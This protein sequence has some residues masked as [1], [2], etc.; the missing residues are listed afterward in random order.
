MEKNVLSVAELLRVGKATD[1]YIVENLIRPGEQLILAGPPKSGKSFLVSELALCLARPFN[2]ENENRFVWAGKGE[3][4]KNPFQVNRKEHDNP[5]SPGWTVL[6]FSLE[7]SA[8]EVSRRLCFQSIK[9]PPK[10]GR[11]E[12]GADA[13]PHLAEIRLHHIFSLP[14]GT[15]ENAEQE[16]DLT[17]LKLAPST[18]GS[19]AQFEPG[20]HSAKIE[21]VIQAFE[22][23][24]V[25]YD[26]LIQLHKLNENDNIQMKS[27]MR[28]LRKITCVA[29]EGKRESV[30]H[31]VL[32]HTRKPQIRD[33]R[34]PT[35]SMMRGAGSIHAVADT[36]MSVSKSKD[37]DREV[38]LAG[39]SRRSGES[40]EGQ[41]MKAGT[42][43][44]TY[45]WIA[46]KEASKSRNKKEKD[47]KKELMRS[48][49]E[50][51][52]EKAGD[53]GVVLTPKIIGDERE[54]LKDLEGNLPVGSAGLATILNNSGAPS[55]NYVKRSPAK[56][57]KH[58]GNGNPPEPGSRIEHWMVKKK[59]PRSTE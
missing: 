9:F 42:E 52:A 36:V 25:I 35:A 38:L 54:A 17:I 5:N 59:I 28:H 39:F 48:V 14:T 23:D 50:R 10:F 12:E 13:P 34:D 19:P 15:G 55:L 20:E 4:S 6:F 2:G 44:P 46:V 57:R 18:F 31:I 24:L 32:H 56:P 45:E 27:L 30:A 7:M 33:G 41:F 53:E 1:S 29:R 51:I 47:K 58:R 26:S 8:Y 3:A 11:I 40:P 37:G 49:L 21:E 43:Q 16:Q 22:P